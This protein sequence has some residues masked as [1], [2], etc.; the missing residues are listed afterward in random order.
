MAEAAAAAGEDP[1]VF[2]IELLRA[3]RAAVTAVFAQPPTNT[4]ADLRALLRHEAHVGGSDGIFVGG[5]PHP[6]AWGTFARF[7]ALHTRELAH[8]TWGEASLHLAGHPARRFGLTGHGLL[9]PWAVADVVVV[10][11][12]AVQDVATYQDP[13]RLAVGIDEVWVNGQRVLRDGELTPQLVGRALP[14]DG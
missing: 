5:R 1:G 3:T 8:W 14:S 9:R 6:R 13:V 4:D 12:E 2:A 10:D 11:P 7:L